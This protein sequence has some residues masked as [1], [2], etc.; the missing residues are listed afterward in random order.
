MEEFKTAVGQ[1]AT[2]MICAQAITHFKP[3]ESYGKYLR[4]LLSVMI[5]VQI[6]Q[7]FCKLFWGVSGQ[8]LYAGVED[9]Q[10]ELD[11]GMRT[12][13]E[14]SV[15]VGKRL[16]SMSLLEVQER[17]AEQEADEWQNST[18]TDESDE[19]KGSGAI[20]KIDKIERMEVNLYGE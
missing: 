6:F 11:A 7:P 1:I 2:F 3:K 18:Q 4:V 12:A 14:Q 10:R 17:L 19:D 15:L 8:E 20:N 16:E 9:F 13:A 5:L